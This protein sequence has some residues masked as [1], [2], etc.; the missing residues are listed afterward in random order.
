[1]LP[2]KTPRGAKALD[3]LKCFEGIPYPYDH[4]KRV[5]VPEALKIIQLRDNR[6]FCSVGELASECGWTKHE[7]VASLEEKRKR[8][9]DKYY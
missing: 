3:R 7:L 8:K 6:K 9:S 4:K 1:M 2:H 5:S